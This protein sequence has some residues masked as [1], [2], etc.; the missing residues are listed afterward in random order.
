MGQRKE[1]FLS[2]DI[3]LIIEILLRHKH[4]LANTIDEKR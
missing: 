2:N 3:L 4:K 1:F